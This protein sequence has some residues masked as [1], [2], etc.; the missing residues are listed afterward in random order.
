MRKLAFIR[1]KWPQ[2]FKI[3]IFWKIGSLHVCCVCCCCSYYCLHRTIQSMFRFIG[4][5]FNYRLT[6]FRCWVVWLLKMAYTPWSPPLSFD[7]SSTQP[8]NDCQIKLCCL[9]VFDWISE[10]VNRQ[11]CIMLGI[12]AVDDKCFF[13]SLNVVHSIDLC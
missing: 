3:T 1:W 13:Q 11:A 12:C 8:S 9:L 4:K 6:I 7:F 2:W 5:L 10:S